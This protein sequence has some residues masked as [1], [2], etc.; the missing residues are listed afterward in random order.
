MVAV[1]GVHLGD[2]GVCGLCI[3]GESAFPENALVK[4]LRN[5]QAK[6]SHYGN[7]FFFFLM[8][9]N[10]LLGQL[11][12]QISSKSKVSTTKHLL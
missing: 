10:K 1:R 11:S 2:G 5:L 6:K 3:R 8:P 9:E 12:K 7:L 4:A